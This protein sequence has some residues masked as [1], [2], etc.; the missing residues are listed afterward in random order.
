MDVCESKMNRR[1][2]L[3]VSAFFAPSGKIAG[4]RAEKL[5]R[6]FV[7]RGWEVDVLTLD[8]SFI[9]PIDTTLS[10]PD[11]VRVFQTRPTIHPQIVQS[12]MSRG[13]WQTIKIKNRVLRG[14]AFSPI[15]RFLMKLS[16]DIGINCPYRFWISSALKEVKGREYD[17]VI[18]TVPPVSAAI[19]AMRIARATGARFVLEYRDP[20][21]DIR[22]GTSSNDVAAHFI[23]RLEEAEQVCLTEASLVCAVS[24]TLGAWAEAKT[25]TPV[26]VLPHGYE[27]S[28][29]KT[30]PRNDQIVSM[31]NDGKAG[32][33]F[34]YAG[35]LLYKRSLVPLFKVAKAIA[36][37]G[38]MSCHVI[39]SGTH[40]AI[41]REQAEAAGASDL[42]ISTGL[43]SLS[44]ANYIMSK[45]TANVV[46]ISEDY[47]YMYPGKLWDS[48]AA[49]RPV[50]V[51]GKAN[52]DSA[53]LVSRRGLGIVLPPHEDVDIATFLEEL[54]ALDASDLSSKA[55]SLEVETI[56]D[57]FVR[58][59][60]PEPAGAEAAD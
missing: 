31:M 54:K 46:L 21:T 39:Y 34:Y 53:Q 30:T 18:G 38:G 60:G 16:A 37:A 59:F 8:P 3:L 56:Y 43:I 36:Q 24:P 49:G 6:A 5:A 14:L 1:R 32:I 44:E 35:V 13:V 50:I 26:W 2:L 25:K 23:K 57:P 33:F 11:G 51:I 7:K 10:I 20:W 55:Q 15:S 41:A 48:I 47:E 40:E 52:G 12:I 27:P 42:L 9:P 45:A 28:P 29:P 19:L 17:L 4:R 22:L 58:E